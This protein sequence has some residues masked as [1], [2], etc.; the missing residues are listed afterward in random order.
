MSNIIDLSNKR[1]MFWDDY[2]VDRSLSDTVAQVCPLGEGTQVAEVPDPII[3]YP[4]ICKVDDEYRMYYIGGWNDGEVMLDDGSSYHLGVKV[5]TSR[6]GINWEF[7]KV[8]GRDDNVAIENVLDNV[9]VYR[10]TNPDCPAEELYKAVASGRYF[11]NKYGLYMFTSADGFDFKIARFITDKGSFD[12]CNTLHYIDGRYVCYIRSW[13]DYKAPAN[14]TKCM[15]NDFYNTPTPNNE[16]CRLRSICVLYSDDCV[17]WSDPV[18]LIYNDD[19]DHQMYTNNAMVYERAPHLMIGFPSRYCERLTW[20]ENY[21]QLS[22]Y[23][24]RWKSY[25]SANPRQ[26]LALTDCLFMFSRDTKTWTRYSE[27]FITP[28]YETE[29]NWVYGDCYPAFGF[30][31][32]GKEYYMMYSKGYHHEFDKPKPIYMYKVRKDGFA[33]QKADSKE[34]LLVT[35]PITFKGN[36][37]HLNFETSAYGYII[38]ELLDEKGNEIEGKNCFEVFGNSIDRKVIFEDGSDFSEYE[39]K[40]IRLRFRMRD[41]KLYSMKFEQTSNA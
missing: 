36:A 13:H 30:I 17:N 9:F 18:E 34:R 21:S 33:C 35:K 38:V 2:L 39:G 10:D 24:R 12:T 32:S 40:T 14:E 28:G 7:P 31:D 26:G 1:E 37:L 15:M 8:N 16:V 4:S 25:N 27:A 11:D 41:A 5:I 22:G 29:H 23:E 20:N 19:L 3:S 6:D